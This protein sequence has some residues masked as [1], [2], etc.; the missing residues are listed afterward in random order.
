M[1]WWHDAQAAFGSAGA[2][3]LRAETT[4]ICVTTR[5]AAAETATPVIASHFPIRN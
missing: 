3:E 2:V 5:I 1:A 4:G